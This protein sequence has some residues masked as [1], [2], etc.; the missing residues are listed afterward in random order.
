MLR[1]FIFKDRSKE[2]AL[3]VTPES[4]VVDYGI[5]IETVNIHDVGDADI[6]GKKTLATIKLE[7]MF[8]ERDYD[9]AD[10]EDEP[11]GYVKTF[12]KWS[13][14]G[15]VLRFI[16]SDTPVNIPVRIESIA[17]GE[18][19]GTNDVYATITLREHKALEAVQIA[20]TSAAVNKPRAGESNTLS[21]DLAYTIQY[22]DTMCAI[23]RKYYGNDKPATYNALARYNG[24]PNANIIMAGRVINIPSKSKL[25]V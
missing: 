10:A 20:D 21:S 18:Q 24:I 4:F 16:V 2:L 22:G 3:P 15:T 6:A 13:L 11:Y 23:C 9:F 1:R 8:P 17:Y 7:C 19:D 25:G 14:R 12:Q 5:R